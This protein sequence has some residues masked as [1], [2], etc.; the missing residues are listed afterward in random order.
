MEVAGG[1]KV[2]EYCAEVAQAWDDL[3]Q[4]SCNGTFMH[5]RRFISYHGERFRD[6]SLVIEDRHG[7]IAGVFPAAE[8]LADPR[9]IVSHPGLTYGGIVHDGSIRGESMVGALQ[10]IAEHYRG[11]GYRFLRYKAIP[12]IY[13]DVPADDDVYALFRL[14]AR[15]YRGDLSATIN[16]A[17]RGRVSQ[18]R[19][20]S[21]R[22]A[23]G[24]RAREC[25]DEV[26]RFWRILEENLM[27]RH[28]ASPVH[29]LPE[30]QLLHDRFPDKISLIV[31]SID[32]DIAGGTVL[33]SAGPVLHMQYTATTELG[34]AVSATDPMMEHAIDLGA[35]RG[36]R[37]F[38]FGICTLDEGRSLNQDLYRFKVSFGAGGVAY[39]HYELA[40]A[41]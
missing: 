13:H 4:R 1:P 29:S 28:G 31:A 38:D 22:R 7:R 39:D 32:D 26:A 27:R 15:R 2:G 34:R 17:S 19:V 24:V 11:T 41:Q 23:E 16:L 36:H 9:L 37:F 20:R 35:K 21:R 10:L 6:R 25:W 33:F 14:G 5:T 12:G 3:V 40:L 8:D 18:Q 30:I